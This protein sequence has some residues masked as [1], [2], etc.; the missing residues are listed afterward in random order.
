M[1]VVR[2]VINTLGNWHH[3]IIVGYLTKGNRI[4]ANVSQYLI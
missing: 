3:D 2:G 1:S 4:A